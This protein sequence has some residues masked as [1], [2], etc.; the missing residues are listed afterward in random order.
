MR[1]DP[2]ASAGPT[3]QEPAVFLPMDVD[4]AKRWRG[5]GREHAGVLGDGAGDALTAGQSGADHLV[6]VSAVVLS[7][8]RALGS[9]AS[10][11]GDRQDAAGLV[12]GG[13]AVEQFAGSPV[14]VVDA[15]A[16]QNRLQAA[17]RVPGGACGGIGGQGVVLLSSVPFRAE[18]DERRQTLPPGS[19]V[20]GFGDRRCD[21]AYGLGSGCLPLRR[22]GNVALAPCP[23]TRLTDQPGASRS[24]LSRGCLMADT[25]QY[26]KSSRLHAGYPTRQTARTDASGRAV[27]AGVGPCRRPRTLS[28]C[29]PSRVDRA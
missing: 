5:K 29:G 28:A 1:A 11:A 15:A 21:A 13:V 22:M 23:G 16:Q 10:L 14:E 6:G 19:G 12:D 7:A 24:S 18:W 8:R 4:R 3:S 27:G 17:T 25:C 20:C 26:Q 2:S 9:A